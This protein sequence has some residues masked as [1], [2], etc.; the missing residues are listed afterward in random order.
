[1]P[2][3]ETTITSGP[4]P[5][6][7]ASTVQPCCSPTAGLAHHSTRPERSISA[8]R[9]QAPSRS[10]RPSGAHAPTEGTAA[11]VSSSSCDRPQALVCSSSSQEATSSPSEPGA[12]RVEVTRTAPSGSRCARRPAPGFENRSRPSRSC[13]SWYCEASMDRETAPSQSAPAAASCPAAGSSGLG[14]AGSGASATPQ[15][16]S[17]RAA[18]AER[19]RLG[20]RP[21]SQAGSEADDNLDSPP[22]QEHLAQGSDLDHGPDRHD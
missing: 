19:S 10:V 17:A 11:A 22:Q 13:V 9:R 3:T 1:M 16:Q 14:V 5:A 6:G 18:S 4:C 12:A 2:R 8:R 21:P 20:P 15:E 7:A